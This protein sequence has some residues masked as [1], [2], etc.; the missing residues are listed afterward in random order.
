MSKNDLHL[1]ISSW[2]D[3]R[4]QDILSAPRMWGESMEAVELQV[5]TLLQVRAVAVDSKRELLEPRRVLDRYV[6][7]LA[8]RYGVRPAQ[9]VHQF[10]GEDESKFVEVLAFLSD[11]LSDH[12]APPVDDFFSRSYLGI[13]LGIKAGQSLAAQTVTSFYETFRHAARSLARYGTGRTGRVE[14]TI[15]VQTDFELEEV[16]ITPRNGVPARAR[17]VLGA[18][19]GQRDLDGS[20]RVQ[21]ALGQMLDLSERAD[22]GASARVEGF[23]Q[24]LDINSRTRA[25]VQTLRILPRGRIGEIKIGGTFV[26]RPIPVR[27]HKGHEPLLLSAMARDLEPS[28]YDHT[29]KI[30]AIDL[31]KGSFSHGNER[32]GRVL[33]YV[34][35]DRVQEQLSRVGVLARVVGM[36]YT[37]RVGHSF[38]MAETLTVISDR[39]LRQ[40]SGQTRADLAE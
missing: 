38:V 3:R 1:T 32:S 39:T 33:C 28:G 4:I 37:P 12:L 27:L 5:L 20:E 17:I 35:S 16:T 29:A 9:P 26:D 23:G 7:I 10:V 34:H 15:E 25:F 40:H 22:T 21:Q 11:A 6:E 2:V 31:D 14:K 36:R 24:E 18:P 13:E 19:Y 8:E 30:R